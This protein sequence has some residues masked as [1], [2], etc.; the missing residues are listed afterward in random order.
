MALHFHTSIRELSHNP[1]GD[2]NEAL[3]FR[4]HETSDEVH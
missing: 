4:L 2:V 1:E 3:F